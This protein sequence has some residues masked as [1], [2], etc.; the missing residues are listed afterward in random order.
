M[1][2]MQPYIAEHGELKLI[3]IPCI[4][5][6][7]MSGKYRHAKEGLLSSTGHFSFVK[8]PSVH[9]G[10]W[11]VVPTQS[12]PDRHAYILCVEVESFDEVPEWYFKTTLPPQKCV[13]VPNKNGD[14]DAACRVVDQYVSDHG[15]AA[16]AEDRKYIICERY[17]YEDEGCGFAK[18]SLPIRSVPEDRRS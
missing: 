18:Y 10:L 15:L 8:N 9:Y 16:A 2:D 14:Y 12:E 13:V 11:P 4:S 7:D 5:L 3:G 17:N 6:R 1:E